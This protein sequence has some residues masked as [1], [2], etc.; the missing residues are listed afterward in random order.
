MAQ[1]ETGHFWLTARRIVR[2]T[3]LYWR[4]FSPPAT[5]SRTLDA[6]AVARAVGG[7]GAAA[8]VAGADATVA[9][10]DASAAAADALA[11]MVA[12]SAVT[13]AAAGA[14]AWGSF[15]RAVA[16]PLPRRPRGEAA[17]CRYSRT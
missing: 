12:A 3:P 17:R 5:R 2:C 15:R 6:A 9:G 10:V 1:A 11:A 14:A 7:A 16:L 8:M 4:R 13:A